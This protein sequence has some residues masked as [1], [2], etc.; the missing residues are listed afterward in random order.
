MAAG[1]EKVVGRADFIGIHDISVFF[2]ERESEGR[3][4]GM[5]GHARKIGM[6]EVIDS[7]RND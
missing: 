3:M 5:M 1:G 7:P 2:G 6:S 4:V